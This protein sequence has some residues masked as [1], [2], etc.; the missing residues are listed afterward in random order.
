MEIEPKQQEK[1]CSP[2]C[3]SKQQ[4]YD[5]FDLYLNEEGGN[6]QALN[7]KILASL[8]QLINKKKTPNLEEGLLD[9]TELEN[10]Q[11]QKQIV[12][13]SG[14][15]TKEGCKKFG[16]EA[17]EFAFKGGAAGISNWY[18]GLSSITFNTQTSFAQ[19]IA[20]LLPDKKKYGLVLLPG[21]YGLAVLANVYFKPYLGTDLGAPEI[22]SLAVLAMANK[23]FKSMNENPAQQEKLIQAATAA[24]LAELEEQ[25]KGLY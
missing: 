15:L 18:Y 12:P 7:C 3:F 6:N 23:Y 16:W 11:D 22:L 4:Q 20:R 9:Y 25:N 13:F 10:E 1:S 2:C 17:A 8:K 24:V 14:L 21:L 5:D 19:N